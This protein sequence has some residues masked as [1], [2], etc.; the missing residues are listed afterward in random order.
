MKKPEEIPITPMQLIIRLR[1]PDCDCCPF[2]CN[3]ETEP[4]LLFEKAADCIETLLKK[5]NQ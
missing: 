2:E 4:C 3:P 5:G 1:N